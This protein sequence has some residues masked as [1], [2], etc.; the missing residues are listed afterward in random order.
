MYNIKSILIYFDV[1]I[2]TGLSLVGILVSSNLALIFSISACI[3]G[4]KR[5]VLGVY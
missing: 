5:L 1:S 3:T 4:T 2:K